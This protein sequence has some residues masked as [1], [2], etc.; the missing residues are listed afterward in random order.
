MAATDTFDWL[1]RSIDHPAPEL[2]RYL[3]DQRSCLFSL[4]SEDE[5]Q[6]FVEQMMRDLKT[7][8]T[9]RAQVHGS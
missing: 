1:I 2:R 6:R 5:R 3:A 8:L 9:Q 7:M 4:R